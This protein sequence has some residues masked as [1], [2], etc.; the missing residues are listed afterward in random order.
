VHTLRSALT[1]QA[2]RALAL[3]FEGLLHL[4]GW[5]GRVFARIQPGAGR[6]L[7][8]LVT[9][10]FYSDNW[11]RSHLLPLAASQACRRLTIVTVHPMGAIPKVEVVRPPALLVR[12][13]GGVVARLAVFAWVA[14]RS[15]PDVVGGFHL[16]FNGLVA[17][18]VARLVGARSLYFSVGG[19]TEK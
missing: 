12:L 3:T 1:R 4:S 18:I 9:G 8:I 5:L 7:D 10:T 15:R 17:G 11:I 14:M 2:L 6:E 19:P 16:L 13:V